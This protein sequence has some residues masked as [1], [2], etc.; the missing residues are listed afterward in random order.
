MGYSRTPP[1]AGEGGVPPTVT[2]EAT[3]PFLDLKRTFDGPGHELAEYT[4]K[5]YLKVADDIT[6][7]IVDYRSLLIS[8]GEIAAP[9]RLRKADETA[10]IASGIILGTLQSL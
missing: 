10:W 2:C 3:G 1:A 5:I 7:Q 6:D 8:L 4:A 9:I